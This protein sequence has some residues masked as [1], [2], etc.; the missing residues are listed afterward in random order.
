[1]FSFFKRNKSQDHQVTDGATTET[2]IDMEARR[3]QEQADKIKA[4]IKHLN[5]ICQDRM[6]EFQ[7]ALFDF[8]VKLRP[9]LKQIQ[10][11]SMTRRRADNLLKRTMPR[12]FEAVESFDAFADKNPDAPNLGETRQRIIE[13]LQTAGAQAQAVLKSDTMNVEQQL[14]DSIDILEASF[15][16]TRQ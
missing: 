13:A 11:D 7:R 10:E 1:M 12:L 9:L 4:M 3:A 16:Y 15:A 2:P 14:E 8:E 5:K 6:P